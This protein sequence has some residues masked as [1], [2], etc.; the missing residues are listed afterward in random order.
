LKGCLDYLGIEM[1]DAWLYGGTGHAF[2]LNIHEEICP[3]GPTAWKTNMIIDQVSFM[4]L[5]ISG[6]F[7]SKYNQ[8]LDD[9]QREAWNF[10]RKSI[11]DGLPVYAWEI[12]IPEFYV[13]YGYDDA[14]Y[15]YSGPGADQGKGPKSWKEL[16]DTGIGLVELYQVK[17]STAKDVGFL[18]KSAFEKV[19]KHADNPADWIFERYASGLKGYDTWIDGLL[20]Q[21]A[22]HFGMGYN[23]AVWSE[24]RNYAVEFL[25][26]AK[27]YLFG[28]S[29]DLIDEGIGCYKIVSNRLAKV[30]ESYPFEPG[31][32]ELMIEVD[33][34]CEEVVG[35]LREASEAERA[36]LKILEEIVGKL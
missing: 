33:E 30:S 25:Q 24:C 6:V 23:A 29:S 11:D 22:N 12:E 19:L 4:G 28:R 26:E 13:I 15:Y 1:T 14:G 16:G 27:K 2:I 35:W 8:N 9:L 17:P 5:M 21:K 20:N 36:A 18:I 32:G 3:S 10:T 7:G 31:G 34:R